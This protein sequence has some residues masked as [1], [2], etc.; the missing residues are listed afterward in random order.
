M[1]KKRIADSIIIK[2]GGGIR[3]VR[4]EPLETE[5]PE[6]FLAETDPGQA[7]DMHP[8]GAEN[9]PDTGIGPEKVSR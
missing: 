6:V 4:R 7:E 8:F 5:T 1:S 3:E 9:G 2:V